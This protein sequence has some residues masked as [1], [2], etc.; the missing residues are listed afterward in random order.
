MGQGRP[1]WASSLAAAPEPKNSRPPSQPQ[2]SKLGSEHNSLL[3][4]LREDDEKGMPRR[5]ICIGAG[6]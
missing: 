1:P 5:G 3:D 2:P 6:S 4:P